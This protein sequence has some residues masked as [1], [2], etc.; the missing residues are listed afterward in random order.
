MRFRPLHFGFIR[1]GTAALVIVL[2]AVLTFLT[3]DSALP[4]V[5]DPSQSVAASIAAAMAKSTGWRHV[6]LVGD[7]VLVLEGRVADGD[8]KVLRDTGLRRGDPRLVNDLPRLELG[9]DLE[10]DAK[11]ASFLQRD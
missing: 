1:P 3:L 11:V 6:K 8:D 10:G 9:V 2:S 4:P 7:R 5:A